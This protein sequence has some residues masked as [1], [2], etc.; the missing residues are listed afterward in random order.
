MAQGWWWRVPVAAL[1]I[2]S[3]IALSIWWRGSWHPAVIGIASLAV[4]IAITRFAKRFAKP[5]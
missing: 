3:T 4:L 2:A 5:S 1:A